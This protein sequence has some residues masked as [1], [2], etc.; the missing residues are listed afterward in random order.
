MHS[1]TVCNCWKIVK[2]LLSLFGTS[3]PTLQHW[4]DIF[5]FSEELLSSLEVVVEDRNPRIKPSISNKQPH[6]KAA[7]WLSW[8]KDV[9]LQL[10]IVMEAQYSG[11][12]PRF[13]CLEAAVSPVS[14]ELS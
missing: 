12:N 8:H 1:A 14:D 7:D 11:R 4:I 9:W 6:S 3:V 5:S 13:Y 10:N 2:I